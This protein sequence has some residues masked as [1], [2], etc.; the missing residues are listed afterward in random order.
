MWLINE[1]VLM[2]ICNVE[3]KVYAMMAV[4]EDNGFDDSNVP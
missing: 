3:A 4:L 1:W 2:V